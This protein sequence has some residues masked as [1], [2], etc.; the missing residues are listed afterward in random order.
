MK[1]GHMRRVSLYLSCLIL[2]ADIGI[3]SMA[4]QLN[5]SCLFSRRF[6]PPQNWL[7]RYFAIKGDTLLYFSDKGGELK[8]SFALAHSEIRIDDEFAK[9]AHSFTIFSVRFAY[10]SISISTWALSFELTLIYTGE[11]ISETS[12]CKSRA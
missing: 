1:Q 8:G 3:I 5:L 2:F 7:R 9:R 10:L 6:V 12:S 4:R 11:G